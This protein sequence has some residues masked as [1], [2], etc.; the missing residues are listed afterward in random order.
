MLLQ[1]LPT[2]LLEV[3]FGNLDLRELCHVTAVCRQWC[4]AGRQDSVIAAASV[5]SGV[6][7]GA[8]LSG[9]LGLQP[10]DVRALP[11]RPFVTSRG[12]TSW[13]YG[14]VAVTKGLKLA[15]ELR[16]DPRQRKRLAVQKGRSCATV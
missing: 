12:Y 7:T 2:E 4:E 3:I 10:K 9:L 1:S 8:Q 13:L 15:R 5:L 6:L 16:R 11:G 14:P